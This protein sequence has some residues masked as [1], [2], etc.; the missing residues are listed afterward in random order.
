MSNISSPILYKSAYQNDVNDTKHKKMSLKIFRNNIAIAAIVLFAA[1]S[2]SEAFHSHKCS[3]TA[4]FFTKSYKSGAIMMSSNDFEFRPKPPSTPPP[5]FSADE[6]D[7]RPGSEFRYSTDFTPRFRPRPPSTPPP[8]S[9]YA[10]KTEEAT[11]SDVATKKEEATTS[12][13]ATKKEDVTTSDIAVKKEDVTKPDEATI[14]DSEQ[15]ELM[16]RIV[17]DMG[18]EF[19]VSY[20][21]GLCVCLFEHVKTPMIQF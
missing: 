7:I 10:T 20:G 2:S 12:D 19:V 11:T 18:E 4:A 6:A 16:E 8:L 1:P 14:P 13:V 21:F 15:I 9:L 5:F 17:A 3:N